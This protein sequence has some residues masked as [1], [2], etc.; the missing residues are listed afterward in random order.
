[1]GFEFIGLKNRSMVDKVLRNR[2]NKKVK[3][4]SFDKEELKKLLLLLQERANKACEIECVKVEAMPNIKDLELIK[5]DLKKCS[6][7]KITIIGINGEELFGSIEEVFASL[8]FPENVKSMYVNSDLQ[9]RVPHK[10][11]PENSF[12]LNIDF[13]KPQ[14]F[15]FS[16]LPSERTSNDSQFEVEGSD[17]TWVNGVFLEIDSFIKYK[18]SKFPTVHKG[19]VYDILV[20]V[21][22]IPFGFWACLKFEN[23]LSAGVLTIHSFI[24][25]ALFVYVFLLSL[26][27]FRILFHYF[28]WVYPMIE[29]RYK[30]ERSL[31]HQAALLS[32]TIG[33]IGKFIYDVIRYIFR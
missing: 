10:Y 15:D 30:S 19:G 3:S 5:S 25:N 32:I 1:M 7:L 16:F 4:L 6:E 29:Y 26:F 28:R 11:Y 8:H 22:G 33:L 27:L 13:S 24:A 21:L 31:I 2:L 20:W 14:V 17:S 12:H 18:P 23:I 9:Y